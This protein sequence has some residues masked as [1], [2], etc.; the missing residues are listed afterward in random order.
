[1]RRSWH[2]TAKPIYESSALVSQRPATGAGEI[3]TLHDLTDKEVAHECEEPGFAGMP[4]IRFAFQPTKSEHR[5]PGRRQQASVSDPASF[6]S[7]SEAH[8][9]HDPSPARFDHKFDPFHFLN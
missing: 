8:R 2:A 3:V 1:M 4:A 9:E 7:P 6:A 5:M